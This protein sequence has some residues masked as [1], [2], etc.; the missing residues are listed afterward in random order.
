MLLGGGNFDE[1]S[2]I[3]ANPAD[4]ACVLTRGHMFDPEA[5]VWSIRNNLHYIGM[6]GCKGKNDT[7]HDLVLSK[8]GTEE[9]W[10]RIKRPI[11]LKFGAKT[12]AEL[13]IAI[14]AEL[15]DERYKQNYSEAARAKHDSNLGR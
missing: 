8:G 2:R 13:A 12:P 3:A 4:Y 10:E 11:G 15:V 14:V 7:V 1:L 6:M 9:E 5:C